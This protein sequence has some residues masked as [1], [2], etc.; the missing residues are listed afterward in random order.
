MN[1]SNSS[2]KEINANL[3]CLTFYG[4]DNEELLISI[5]N[6]LDNEGNVE[7]VTCNYQVVKLAP[8]SEYSE[9]FALVFYKIV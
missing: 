3:K 1:K 4:S 2:K 9:H 8:T 5:E 6:W 7:I